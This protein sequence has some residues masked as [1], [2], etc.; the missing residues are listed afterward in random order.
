MKDK[1]TYA[2]RRD[3][4]IAA[5]A[6]RRRVIKEKAITYKGGACTFCGYNRCLDALDFHHLDETKKKFGLSKDGITGSWE[7]TVKELDK[8]IIVCSNCHREIHAGI[9]QPS[10]AIQN[11]KMG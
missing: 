10:E 4:L 2:D 1:R 7:K 6:K 3:Y 11:G 9:L 5:V 8:C